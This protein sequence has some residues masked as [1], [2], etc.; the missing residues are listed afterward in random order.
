VHD[1][2]HAFDS[3]IRNAEVHAHV[4]AQWVRDLPVKPDP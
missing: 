3:Q 2:A 1:L 4:A